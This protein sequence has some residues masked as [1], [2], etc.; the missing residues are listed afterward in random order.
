MSAVKAIRIQY[1]FSQA[2]MADYLG[3]SKS[4][5]SL[6]ELRLRTLPTA[7]L[8]RLRT[9]DASYQKNAR[10]SAEAMLDNAAKERAALRSQLKQALE[11]AKLKA[12]R[13]E[14]E[15]ARE[16]DLFKAHQLEAAAI[17]QLLK[18]RT[19]EPQP[20]RQML[21]DIRLNENENKLSAYNP[22]TH[23]LLVI[24]LKSVKQK[25]IFLEKIHKMPVTKAFQLT[26]KSIRDIFA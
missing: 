19:R 1:G 16:E 15:V 2:Q 7:A 24:E 14:R 9:L 11:D 23:A 20:G 10:E 25:I 21:L 26:P 4:L 8:L 6:V 12:E 17:K 3:V 5:V 18:V 13:L 22:I